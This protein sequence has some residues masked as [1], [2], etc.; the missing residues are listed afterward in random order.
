M[1]DEIAVMYLGRIVECG[2]TET[3]LKQA[4][5]PYTQALLAAV[6]SIHENNLQQLSD[7]PMIQGE[8][9]SP[10]NPPSGCHFHPRCPHVMSICRQT[11][12]KSRRVGEDHMAKCYLYPEGSEK[13]LL[14]LNKS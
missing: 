1:A 4:K 3:I 9:P 7:K 13:E 8:Q 10:I 14:D 2:K 6:P 5:H 11:Y 12:P